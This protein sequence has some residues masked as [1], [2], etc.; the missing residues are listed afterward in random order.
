MIRNILGAM[1]SMST[2]PLEGV[3]KSISQIGSGLAS[4]VKGQQGVQQA[5]QQM[6]LMK[7]M[8]GP[9]GPLMAASLSGMPYGQGGAM[10]GQQGALPGPSGGPGATAFPN[11][12]VPATMRGT[13][14]ESPAAAG[15]LGMPTAATMGVQGGEQGQ[16][17]GNSLLRMLSLA[18][19]QLPGVPA[20][21][22]ASPLYMQLKGIPLGYPGMLMA[23]ALRPK[24]QLV[25]GPYGGTYRTT[26]GGAE[27]IV[28]GAAPEPAKRPALKTQMINGQ[29][30]ELWPELGVW[31]KAVGI[32]EP[33]EKL[34]GSFGAYIAG[35][36][37]QGKRAE[38]EEMMRWE[39]RV[40]AELKPRG[41]EEILAGITNP[42]L[43]AEWESTKA[44]GYS[45][46]ERLMLV[47]AVPP[48]SPGMALQQ[49]ALFEK[50]ITPLQRTGASISGRPI[51]TVNL[52][53][54]THNRAAVE[55]ISL[56]EKTGPLLPV[57]LPSTSVPRATPR[58]G[59]RTVPKPTSGP[60]TDEQ[61]IEWLNK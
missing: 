6:Q 46:E 60:V 55:M 47:T 20:P 21:E 16:S 32:P 29:L 25:K 31:K 61:V 44:T 43:R 8:Q 5:Q 14:L 2:M 38:A 12:P 11:M 39:A 40:R 3:A 33:T 51:G 30:Y 57:E 59:V 22:G 42:K 26:R 34:P 9:L 24:S 58:P 45:S 19:G 52:V 13:P 50:W 37:A 54:D 1:G 17:V 7:L 53:F 56:A 23:Q 36:L 10:Q 41:D 4:L 27:Q 28:P 15:A 48:D 35:L 49:Q 18:V